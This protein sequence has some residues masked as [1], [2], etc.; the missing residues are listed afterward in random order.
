MY[1]RST[2]IWKKN[3]SQNY[4]ESYFGYHRVARVDLKIKHANVCNVLRKRSL[5]TAN[6]FLFND[7]LSVS[8]EEMNSCRILEDIE[9]GG[10]T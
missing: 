7:P 5:A 3:W 4:V 8:G 6:I 2:R 1:N 9:D 10:A